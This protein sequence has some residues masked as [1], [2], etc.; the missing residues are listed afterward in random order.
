VDVA[1]AFVVPAFGRPQWLADCLESLQRQT[2]RSRILIATSTPN[3]HIAR[4]ADQ[5]GI[6][7]LVNPTRAGIA[8]DW[9]FALASTHARW[10]TLAHQDDWYAPTYTERCLAAAAAS[11]APLMVFSSAWE[12]TA[13]GAMAQHPWIKRLLCETAFLGQP[14]IGSSWRKRLLLSFGDPIPCPT[15]MLNR[16]LQPDFFFPPGFDAAL[17][18]V[19]WLALARLPGDFVYVREPLVHWRVHVSSATHVHGASLE[20]EDDRVLR[21]LWP[22]PIAG[23]IGRL[24]ASGRRKYLS[25]RAE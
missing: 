15:V 10:V 25:P 2:V 3:D 8:G 22:R 20:A 6:E 9:N 16:A 24:Y 21:S 13:D 18:W 19:A 12:R 17:D 7:V 1:H 4:A 5:A 23:L 11:R 14:A